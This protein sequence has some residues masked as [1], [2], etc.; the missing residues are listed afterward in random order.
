MIFVPNHSYNNISH[1][2]AKPGE[3]RVT[4]VYDSHYH[5]RASYIQDTFSPPH[6]YPVIYHVLKNN[7]PRLLWSSNNTRGHFGISK[8][9]W[10]PKSGGTGFFKDMDG[11]YGLSEFALG[12]AETPEVIDTLYTIFTSPNFQQVFSAGSINYKILNTQVIRLFRKDFWKE[13]V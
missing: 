12:I 6:V 9:V 4:V 5:S 3:E 13:F 8:F 7:T 10:N 1:L 11:T 2:I